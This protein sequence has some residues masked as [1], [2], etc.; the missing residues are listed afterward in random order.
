[1]ASLPNKTIYGQNC[2]VT[3]FLD[4]ITVPGTEFATEIKITQVVT[5]HRRNYL[6][7]RRSVTD[8]HI[9]G[10]DASMK[11]DVRDS[12]LLDQLAL[13]DLHRDENQPVE[14]LSLVADFT[15]RNGVDVVYALVE[16][17]D[18]TD[19]DSG[20]RVKESEYNVEIQAQDRV[21]VS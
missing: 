17:E 3:M 8:K 11:M 18:K 10:Y 12:R 2:Q 15:L 7:R 19:I 9:D 14:S 5:M 21:K 13:R 1:M 16:C 4:G 20:D 6:G